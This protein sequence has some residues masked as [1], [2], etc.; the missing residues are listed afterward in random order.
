[1]SALAGPFRRFSDKRIQALLGG[2]LSRSKLLADA[3]LLANLTDL[4]AQAA[5]DCVSGL[6]APSEREHRPMLDVFEGEGQ[7]A[8]EG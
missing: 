6:A 8:V 2:E 1:M 5:L 4:I 7:A 3:G